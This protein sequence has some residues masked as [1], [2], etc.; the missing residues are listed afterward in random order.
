MQPQE[1]PPT[2]RHPGPTPRAAPP[3]NFH[4]SQAY[5]ALDLPGDA[6]SGSCYFGASGLAFERLLRAFNYT[7]VAFDAPGVN[8]FF[9]ADEELGAR[10][11]AAHSFGALAADYALPAYGALH[12]PCSQAVW[13]AVEGGAALAGPDFARLMR[14]AVLAHADVG[15]RVRAAWPVRAFR[16]VDVAH[17]GLALRRRRHRRHH[18]AAAA[19]RDR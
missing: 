4:P 3:R 14:P 9:V 18:S 6:W 8:L 16:E 1:T 17:V 19:R 13:L 5:A 11:P 15:A 10:P 2:P 7:L 12:G